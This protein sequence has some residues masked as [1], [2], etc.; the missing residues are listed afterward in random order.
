MLAST[1]YYLETKNTHSIEFVL[2]TDKKQEILPVSKQKR[3][4]VPSKSVLLIG[5]ETFAVPH[6]LKILQKT[7]EKSTYIFDLQDDWDDEGSIGYEK[8]TWIKAVNFVIDYAKW[9]L[10]NFDEVMYIPKIYHGKESG[11][12]ILWENSEYRMLIRLDKQIE[13]GFFYSDNL[14]KQTSE[15]EFQVSKINYLM[16]PTPISF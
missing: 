1:S 2:R 6:E 8:T 4:P 15:G 5:G 13:K 3:I 10:D 14:H 12:D 7:I 16:L 9:I 11:I